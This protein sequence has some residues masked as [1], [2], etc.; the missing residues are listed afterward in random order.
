MA[1]SRL[2]REHICEGMDLLNRPERR[3]QSRIDVGIERSNK[4]VAWS[5]DKWL[6]Y[7]ADHSSV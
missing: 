5:W 6:K 1:G 4:K 2:D 3:N 7:V